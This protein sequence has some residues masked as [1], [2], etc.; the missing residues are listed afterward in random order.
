MIATVTLNPSLDKTLYVD[1]LEVDDS[2][3]CKRFRYDPGGKGLNISRVL[4]ELGDPSLLF[5][6]L[7]GDTGRRVEKY[8]RDEGLTCD[9]NW[10]SGETRENI[11]LTSTAEPMTQTKINLPGPT[12][13]ED[14]VHRLKRKLAGRAREYQTL[15]LSG[16]VPPGLPPTIYRDLAEDA[17]L[18]GDRVV[19]D[20]DGDVLKA[21]MAAAPFMI[22]PNLHELQRLVGRELA[23]DVAIHGALDELLDAHAVELIV[24]TRGHKGVVAATRQMRLAAVPPPCEARTSVGAGDSMIAGFLHAYRGPETL[25]EALCWGVA[26]GTACVVSPGTELAHLADVQRFRSQ[27]Q[28]APLRT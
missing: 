20:A 23:D 5:G 18:R 15:V 13:R 19:L 22:K 21:G 11:I 12:I 1:A 25:A 26:A 28:V 8:L 10:T 4:W 17:R 27:V 7:G 24:L 9:F 2:N 14:E 3:R 6:F 16:S